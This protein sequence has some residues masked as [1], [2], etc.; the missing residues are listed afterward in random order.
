MREK[1]EDTLFELE[2]AVSRLTVA[3]INAQRCGG[4]MDYDRMIEAREELDRARD[5][6]V[7]VLVA[8]AG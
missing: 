8:L 5:R 6:A 7:A 3:E 2:A 4:R 1:I